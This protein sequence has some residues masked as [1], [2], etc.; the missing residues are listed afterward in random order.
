MSVPLVITW[1]GH[2]TTLLDLDGIRGLTDPVLGD[3]VGPLVRLGRA[4]GLDGLEGVAGV[5]LRVWGWG[6]WLGPGHLD[7]A[8][9]ATAAALIAPRLAV[10]IHWGTF[11]LP[12]PL[13]SR[14]DPA[15]PAR[16]FA[17][18]TAEHAPAVEV[19]VPALG[20]RIEGG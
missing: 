19:R 13:R 11:G 4:P 9:A 15:A 16:E 6:P 7:P 17:A 8:R 1:L 14:R 5:L 2:A 10:P 12:R 18:L 20:Q 3:R